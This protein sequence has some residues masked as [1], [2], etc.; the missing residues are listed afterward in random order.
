MKHKLTEPLPKFN[1][2][3]EGKSWVG[4][5]WTERTAL[6]ALQAG[7]WFSSTIDYAFR[8]AEAGRFAFAATRVFETL[9]KETNAQTAQRN[10]ANAP[11][12]LSS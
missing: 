9:R 1:W 2:I 5:R 12:R 10:Q 7:Q 8:D 6:E 11:A 4:H 3:K